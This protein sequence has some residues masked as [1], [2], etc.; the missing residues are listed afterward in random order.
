M[1]ATL[2]FG[3]NSRF[4]ATDVLTEKHLFSSNSHLHNGESREILLKCDSNR[5][6]YLSNHT[7]FNASLTENY[8]NVKILVFGVH[9]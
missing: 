2:A 6:F 5:C 1:S 4:T 7:L 8:K 9:V 3:C